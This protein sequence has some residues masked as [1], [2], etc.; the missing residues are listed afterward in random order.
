MYKSNISTL[1]SVSYTLEE[2]LDDFISNL[3][4]SHNLINLGFIH[5]ATPKIFSN[6][7]MVEKNY[8]V[9]SGWNYLS[10]H[11]N[12]PGPLRN[13]LLAVQNETFEFLR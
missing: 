10:Q 3:G 6:N 9:K 2:I 8:I 13:C 12:H 5:E 4:F 1:E 7:S 11:R